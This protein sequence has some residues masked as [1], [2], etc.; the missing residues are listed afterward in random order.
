MRNTA[1]RFL[2][3]IHNGPPQR[4]TILSAPAL[5]AYAQQLI[6]DAASFSGK[7]VTLESQ[8]LERSKQL[9]A[10]T[11]LK[12]EMAEFLPQPIPT[13]HVHHYLIDVAG[14]ASGDA[15]AQATLKALVSASVSNPDQVVAAALPITGE[16]TIG[17][18]EAVAAAMECYGVHTFTD[19]DQYVGYLAKL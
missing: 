19:R 13:G 18:A 5:E 10:L 7:A 1:K 8:Q 3:V 9:Q 14:V 4:Y 12:E 17:T 16:D 11:S 2:D 15:G 6:D